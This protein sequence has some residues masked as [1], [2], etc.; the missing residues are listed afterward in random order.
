MITC[1]FCNYCFIFAQNLE[2]YENEDICSHFVRH[3]AADGV[4]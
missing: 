2:S 4:W 3:S 1:I